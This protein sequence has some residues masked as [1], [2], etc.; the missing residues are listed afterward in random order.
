MLAPSVMR[1][2]ITRRRR[3]IFE[4]VLNHCNANGFGPSYEEIAAAFGLRSLATV[5]E[6][7]HGLIG[8]GYLKAW[9]GRSVRRGVVPVG[10]EY[11]GQVAVPVVGVWRKAFVGQV[12]AQLGLPISRIEAAVEGALSALARKGEAPA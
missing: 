11:E 3:Q 6:H 7:V 2:P 4:F 1:Q 12:A 9:H 8:A 5:H 10:F